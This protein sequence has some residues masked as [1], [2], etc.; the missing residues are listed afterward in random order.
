MNS[1]E[2]DRIELWGFRIAMMVLVVAALTGVFDEYAMHLLF[3]AL[4]LTLLSNGLNIAFGN[5]GQLLLCQAAFFGFAAYTSSLLV[6]RLG[7]TLWL[8]VPIAFVATVALGLLIGW[9]ASRTAGHYF[10]MF[11]LS[12][13]IV[14]H[15]IVLNWESIT[16]G[17]LGLRSIPPFEGFSV[18]GIALS[19]EKKLAYLLSCVLVVW[20]STELIGVLRNSR[21]GRQFVAI[22]EDEVAAASLGIKTARLK[23]LA[24]VFSAAAAGIAGPLY[25]HYR[26]LI[27]PTDFSVFQSVIVLLIVIVGGSNSISGPLI[28]AFVVTLLPELLRT[29][30]D[31]RWV[32][33]G[34]ALIVCALFLPGG[35]AKGLRG[36]YARLFNG[37]LSGTA[38]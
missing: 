35:I 36:T 24:V 8:A 14:F 22:R 3:V 4:I 2:V 19:F 15:Q 34:A 38:N 1:I 27:S 6:I 21:L 16:Q 5:S 12:V 23:I 11:T 17:A 10:A 29:A 20:V 26:Q 32:A 18:F 30:A 25:A 13:S 9:V 7:F 33:F 31:L 28:G 37:Q